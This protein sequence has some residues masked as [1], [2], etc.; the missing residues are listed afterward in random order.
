MRRATGIWSD[1]LNHPEDLQWRNADH[2]LRFPEPEQQSA[3]LVWS[4]ADYRFRGWVQR[5]GTGFSFTGGGGACVA[6]NLEGPVRRVLQL[7]NKDPR[8]KAAF[9]PHNYHIMP[10]MLKKKHKVE[11][12]ITKNYWD[13]NASS[14]RRSFRY[15]CT[16]L[17]FFCQRTYSK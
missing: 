5:R 11:L 2:L 10:R 4:S 12:G 16:C 17:R 3:T 1:E 9:S 14:S 7:W 6:S 15:S 13:L 8:W